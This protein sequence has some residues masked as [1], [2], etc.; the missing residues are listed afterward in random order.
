LTLPAL[1]NSHEA[2]PHHLPKLRVKPLIHQIAAV[3]EQAVGV[4]VFGMVEM[5]IFV[6]L[7]FLENEK[8]MDNCKL[9]GVL[10]GI[11]NSAQPG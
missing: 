3:V 1:L 6:A 8:V 10:S 11:A 7:G 2:T 4:V 5:E 9:S